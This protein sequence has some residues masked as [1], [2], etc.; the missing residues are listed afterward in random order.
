M[1]SKR[2]GDSQEVNAGSMAD[3]AFLLLI[4]F[5]VTTTIASDKGLSILLPPHRSEEDLSEFKMKDKNVFKVLVN[6]RNML[7]V[8]DEPMSIDKLR[9]SVKEFVDNRGKDPELSDSPTDGAVSFK[10]DRGTRYDVYM[11]VFDEV[12]A[13]Y[14]ELRAE[15]LG[16]SLR[17]YLGFDETE[18]IKDERLIRKAELFSQLAG[19]S[20][21]PKEYLNFNP[22]RQLKLQRTDLVQKY[23]QARQSGKELF[24]ERYYDSARE[25]PLRIS[26]AE[27]TKIGG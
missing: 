10:T 23:K 12:K 19:E 9:I 16:I 7:L 2:R 13:A 17:D 25:Y 24:I 22:E 6:S 26:E 8:E 14:H 27:P 18:P 1:K 15:Y 21:T 5:L 4:F 11:R 3:I 20:Y